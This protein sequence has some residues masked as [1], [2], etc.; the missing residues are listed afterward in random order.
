MTTANVNL[1]THTHTHT[2]SLAFRRSDTKFRK[3]ISLKLPVTPYFLFREQNYY[4]E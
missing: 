4:I 2:H 1:Y 3:R